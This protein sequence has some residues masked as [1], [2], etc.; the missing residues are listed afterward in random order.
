MPSKNQTSLLKP[1]TPDPIL[2]GLWGSF[3]QAFV[4]E[5]MHARKVK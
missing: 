4:V 1:L 3:L 5:D 2:Y